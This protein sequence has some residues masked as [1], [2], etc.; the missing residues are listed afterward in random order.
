M[1]DYLVIVESPAKSKTISK[2][3]GKKYIV[4]ASVGHVRDLPKSTLGIDID[5]DF[6]PK[7]ITIR[8][9]GD[10]I[11]KLKK[12]AK[13]AKK[14]LLATD[15]DREG[16]AIS[17][18]LAKLLDIDERE[19]CR[20]TFNE[21]TKNTV[22]KSIKEPRQ[23]NMNL[24]D[25]QQARRILDRI[26]GYKISPLLWS[27]VRRGLSAGRVQ[28]VATRII[29][30]RE[31]EIENFEP[32]EYWNIIAHLSKEGRSKIMKARFYGEINGKK[33]ELENEEQVNKIL[34]AL[35][36]KD[37]IVKEIK[38]TQ[39]PKSPLPPFTTSTLQQ[40]ASRKLGFST[41]KTM[42]LA[43]QLYEG[44]NIK[45][46]GLTGLIT[47][48]RTDSV[49]V[50][51][52]AL[53]DAREVIKN[54]FGEEYLHKTNRLYSKKNAAQDAHEAI[55]PTYSNFTPEDIK[56]SLTNDQYKLYKL[57]WDRFIACQMANAI[58]DSVTVSISAGDYIFRVSGSKVNFLGYMKVYTEGKDNTTE[59]EDENKSFPSLK[60]G[61]LLINKGIEPKQ[62]FTQPPPRY[63]EATLVKA[64]EEKGIGR[65]STYAPTIT[66]I[67]ARGYVVKEKKLL[68]PTELGRIVNDLIKKNFADIVDLEFT[69]NMESMLD[70]IEKGTA[71]WV[72]EIKKFYNNFAEMVKKAEANMGKVEIKDEVS[73]V[74]CEKCGRM[75]VYK[76]SRYGKFL[77][78]P[79]FPECRNTK[80][81]VEEAG[82]P[83]PLCSR[84]VIYK[85]TRSGKR[86]LSC[87]G[88]PE[89]T[90]ASWDMPVKDSTCEKCGSFMVRHFVGK[91]RSY[92][93]CSN[94][95][96]ETNKDK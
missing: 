43:Q 38:E 42:M 51:E 7:Y 41:K 50:S 32:K 54:V 35:E 49:R 88:Y 73:D 19:A 76:M 94:P 87:S 64:L 92:I 18:H 26:V 58:I 28:S 81:I 30:D 68:Y 17:W 10:V 75:M 13:T 20:V 63:T 77:A 6:T 53:K 69:A 86:Y 3:L 72:S 85:K 66:T 74:V 25:A 8:G 71:E 29:C 34:K 39:K 70:N 12:H 89:C 2:Y 83:C 48:M 79:G 14:I 95:N 23:I 82:V 62:M 11:N 9:K 67:M 55:R 22:L 47:Y 45:G 93:T 15:P 65:P 33:M 46:H 78:C 21:I 27:N 60:E 96:C 57:I 5:N 16:E 52:E 84:P 44:V 1:S 40:E 56:A 31:E 91:N 59:E 24:V 80:T 4:E 90:F 36:G 37:F 61:E